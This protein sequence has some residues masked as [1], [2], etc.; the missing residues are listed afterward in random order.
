[1]KINYYDLSIKIEDFLIPIFGKVVKLNYCKTHL[2]IEDFLAAFRI[3]SFCLQAKGRGSMRGLRNSVSPM[4]EDHVPANL[5]IS[6]G[7]D[8]K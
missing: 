7:S 1:M 8:V 3:W 4:I 5:P 6:F 2:N